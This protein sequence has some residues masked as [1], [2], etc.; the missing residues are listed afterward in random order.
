ML[1]DLLKINFSKDKSGTPNLDNNIFMDPKTHTNKTIKSDGFNYSNIK[2]GIHKIEKENPDVSGINS[3]DKLKPS[4]D[5]KIKDEKNPYGFMGLDPVLPYEPISGPYFWRVPNDKE[6]LIARLQN[7][8]GY[9]NAFKSKL[10]NYDTKGAI[11]IKGMPNLED[12][13]ISERE[14]GFKTILKAIN[15]TKTDKEPTNEELEEQQKHFNNLDNKKINNH[16]TQLKTNSLIT[17]SKTLKPTTPLKVKS[18]KDIYYTTEEDENLKTSQEKQKAEEYKKN[19]EEERKKAENEKIYTERELRQ[20]AKDILTRQYKQPNLTTPIKE[21]DK[22]EEED[23]DDKYFYS[24]KSSKK[25]DTE[26][27]QKST[28]KKKIEHINEI[29]EE[30]EQKEM[31]ELIDELEKL[32]KKYKVREYVKEKGFPPISGKRANLTYL[33][34]LILNKEKFE[35]RETEKKGRGRTPLTEDAKQIRGLEKQLQKINKQDEKTIAKQEKHKA[36]QEQI[37]KHI[38]ANQPGKISK[39]KILYENA[40]Y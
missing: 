27:L 23:A 17:K 18:V 32:D 21:N 36:L 14:K 8:N 16:L 24:P 5:F 10:I 35:E 40:D 28:V 20:I 12:K 2:I 7:E 33:R 37:Y 9:D 4:Y 30:Q 3:F 26:L 38:K 11:D 19:A 13:N 1:S 39:D 34:N 25:L 29:T 31:K 6:L 15:E 22:N